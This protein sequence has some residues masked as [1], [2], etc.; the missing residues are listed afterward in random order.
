[1]QGGSADHDRDTDEPDRDATVVVTGRAEPAVTP[2]PTRSAALQA[3]IERLSLQGAIFL[4]AEYREPWAYES[5]SGPVTANLLRPGTDRVILFHVVASGRCW[6]SVADGPRHWAGAGDVIVLPYG[7]QHR[8]G[9]VGDAGL[10]SLET[11]LDTPPWTQMPVLRHGANG[12]L[13]DVVCGYLHSRD[14]LFDPDLRVFPPAFVVRPPVGTAADWVRANVAF[15]LQQT[16]A[17]PSRPGAATTRLP[18]LLLVEILR[19]H[20]A[21]APAVESGWANALHDPV[22]S[23][24]IA[25]LHRAPEYKWTVAELAKSASVSRSML[26]ARFRQVLGRS[27]IRYLTEWRMHLAQDLLATTDLGIVSVARRVGY[28]AEEAF[29]RAFK[30]AHGAPPSAWR[31]EHSRR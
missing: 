30:R 8:M 9:G 11:F 6:V 20:L 15:A 2:V 10:V 24:A 5:L 28:D 29:S 27:P 31:A 3:A 21:T 13:T 18:E 26:D 25:S 1:M 12:S 16:S 14:P 4:R 22:L 19:L 23:P 17:A 7:D